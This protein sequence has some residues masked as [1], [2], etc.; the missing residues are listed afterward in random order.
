MALFNFVILLQV[1]RFPHCFHIVLFLFLFMTHAQYISI[2][3]YLFHIVLLHCHIFS[4]N[5]IRIKLMLYKFIS[6]VLSKYIPFNNSVVLFKIFEIYFL[7]I[8]VYRFREGNILVLCS[9]HFWFIFQGYKKL[10]VQ[11]SNVSFPR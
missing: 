7:C 11:L 6:T 3:V 9:H 2:S 1:V 4:A 5:I 8:F 10:L